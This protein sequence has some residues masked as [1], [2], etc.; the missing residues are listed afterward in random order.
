[1]FC[2]GSALPRFDF[3]DG[4][5]RFDFLDDVPRFDFRGGLPRFYF[6]VVSP[7]SVSPFLFEVKLG[8]RADAGPRPDAG[9]YFFRVTRISRAVSRALGHIV[10]G[11]LKSDFRGCFCSRFFKITVSRVFSRVIFLKCLYRGNFRWRF[12]KISVFRGIIDIRDFR[13]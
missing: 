13:F 2:P 11:I 6:Y 8:S 3:L 1:M 5:P 7:W 12:A 4:V 10:G 9:R